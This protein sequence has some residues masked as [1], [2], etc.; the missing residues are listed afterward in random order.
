MA[1]NP[2]KPMTPDQIRKGFRD[3]MATVDP[4]SAGMAISIQPITINGLSGFDLDY[5]KGTE[6]GESRVVMLFARGNRYTLSA[7]AFDTRPGEFAQY[8][9]AID[10]VFRSFRLDP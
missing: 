2:S 4:S 5:G 8:A 1:V 7:V 3:C 10:A 6:W 9:P